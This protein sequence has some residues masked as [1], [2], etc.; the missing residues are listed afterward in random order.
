MSAGSFA[1]PTF[2]PP[3]ESG[4]DSRRHRWVGLPDSIH[5]FAP[6]L[7]WDSA[8]PLYEA[9]Q[10]ADAAAK[11]RVLIEERPDQPY[12]HF[13]T[14]CCESL[15]GQT[16]EAIEHLGRAI[17]MWDGCREMARHDSDFDAIR[18]EPAFEPSSAERR[19]ESA[20]AWTHFRCGTCVRPGVEDGTLGSPTAGSSA[21]R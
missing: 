3:T 11:G 12:L 6:E 15:A 4:Y 18:T 9:G 14:A 10:Y 5:R 17:E 1:D 8:R 21:A 19:V 20:R 13:N 7:W 2:P 16:T